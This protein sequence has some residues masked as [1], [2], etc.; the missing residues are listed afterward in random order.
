MAEVAAGRGVSGVTGVTLGYVYVCGA[1]LTILPSCVGAKEYFLLL[2]LRLFTQ[3]E[4][5]IFLSDTEIYLK[6]LL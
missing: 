4:K 1:I 5:N 3:L 6:L 2:M